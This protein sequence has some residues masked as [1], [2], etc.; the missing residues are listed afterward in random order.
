MS[1]KDFDVQEY[2]K[3]NKFTLNEK[4]SRGSYQKATESINHR[5]I[6]KLK[7]AISEIEKDLTDKG[8]DLKD[9]Y[10]FLESYIALYRL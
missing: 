1:K 7:E 2:L 6:V 8:F 3:E 4:M 5:N 9:V 10:D